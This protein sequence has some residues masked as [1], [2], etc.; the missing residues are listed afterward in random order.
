MERSRSD[1]QRHYEI[2]KELAARLRRAGPAER[3]QC[4]GSLYDELLE[5]V[6]NHPQTILVDN[7]K[8]TQ[9]KLA[10]QLRLLNGYLRPDTIFLEVGAGDCHLAV[11]VAR[12]VKKV[13]AV[14]VSRHLTDRSTFPSNF[15]LI[16]SDGISI[17]VP[18][19]SVS[20]AYSYQLME[21][22][23]PDDASAQ[24]QNIYTALAAGGVYICITP[25]RIVGPHDISKYF[26]EIATGL[27]LKEYTST[28]LMELFRKA[29]FSKTAAYVSGRSILRWIPIRAYETILSRLPYPARRKII[30]WLPFGTLWDI[31]VVGTKK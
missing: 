9:K 10:R 12:R 25:N 29:R 26:D 18:A 7:P 15:E 23:H 5:R 13:Y 21:H 17:P 2:E 3:R 22:L 24:L 20:V 1:I 6:P 27:H 30:A 8:R 14:D 31:V 16:V 11:E 19:G 4:Y 28:E